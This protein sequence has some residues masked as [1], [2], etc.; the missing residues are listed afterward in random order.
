M[1]QRD[2]S[3]ILISKRTNTYFK[4]FES[5]KEAYQKTKTNASIGNSR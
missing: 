2:Q 5:S 3:M 4:K 1:M